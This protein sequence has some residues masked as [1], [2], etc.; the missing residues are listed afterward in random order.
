MNASI[1]RK[2]KLIYSIVEQHCEPGNQNK[3]RL[4]AYR[5]Y[6]NPV[7]PMCERSFWRYMKIAKKEICKHKAYSDKK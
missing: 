4:Q 3:C 2:A 6:V 5:K 1:I 7:Y